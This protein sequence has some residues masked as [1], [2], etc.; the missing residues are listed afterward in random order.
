MKISTRIREVYFNNFGTVWLVVNSLF[1]QASDSIRNIENK[2][3]LIASLNFQFNEE[4]KTRTEWDWHNQL[5]FFLDDDIERFC[6]R[7]QIVI[8]IFSLSLNSIILTI[9][10][11]IKWDT[12]ICILALV[13]VFFLVS[14][15][16]IS[17]I[18]IILIFH[19]R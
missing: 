10:Y 15:V 19:L 11:W 17:I 2:N 6:R 16:L 1:I 3:K 4:N 8:C 5:D 18:R 12:R 9:A 14:V 13:L 7:R